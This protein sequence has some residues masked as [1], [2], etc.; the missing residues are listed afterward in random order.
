MYSDP[1]TLEIKKTCQSLIGCKINIGFTITLRNGTNH[2]GEI[3]N[4][5][6]VGDCMENI[7]Y[8]FI[9]KHIPTFKKGPKQASPD[10]YN[11][12]KKWGWEL[13]CFSKNPRFDIS[14]F[15]SYISQIQDNLEKKMYKTQYL[16]FKYNLH[17]LA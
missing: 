9:C 16:I 1:D 13:K 4:C 5:N 14:N 12:D 10:F 2:G 17:V 11:R 15:N 3:D 6:I 7:L 8:P